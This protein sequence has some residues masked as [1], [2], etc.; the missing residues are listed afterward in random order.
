MPDSSLPPAGLHPG[1]QVELEIGTLAYGGAGVAR[2]DGFVVLVDRALPGERIQAEITHLSRRFARGRVLQIVSSSP[3]RQDPPCRHE[4][5]CGGCAYQA[6]PYPLQLESKRAQVRELLQRIGKVESPPVGAVLPAPASFG[7][8]RRMSYTFSDE[9]SVGPG[10]HRRADP[11]A[12][13]EV[14]GCLL[15]EPHLQRT[16]ERLLEDLRSLENSQSSRHLELQSG[17]CSPSPV[18]LFRGGSLPSRELRRLADTW[19]QGGILRGVLWMQQDSTRS[20]PEAGKS[21]LLAGV[22]YVEEVL[23]EFRLRIPAGTFFQANPPLAERIFQ[24]IAGRCGEGQESILELYA[25]VGALTLF[26]ARGGRRVTAVE[27]NPDSIRAARENARL[28]G[29]HAIEWIQA[30]IRDSIA[31][32]ARDG[33][34]FDILALDPPRSGLPRD[35]ARQLASVA[36][37]R[38]LYLSC[39]PATLARDVRDFISDG[40][41]RL[42]EVLPVDFFPHTAGI[43]CLAVLEKG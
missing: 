40:S 15:P 27:G 30:D 31:R 29:F 35:G 38:I 10:L 14:P 16:Y 36:R 23:A 22:A 9:E 28:N 37:R 5:F 8:R 43:E 19:V 3:H 26:L 34:A 39:D 41:W 12:V 11:A 17:S 1:A 13:L 20:R 42:K 21:Q 2:L 33:A 4:P 25:G 18:A 6:L 32:W 24:E 7:Y